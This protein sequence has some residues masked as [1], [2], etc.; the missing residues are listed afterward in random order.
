M[1]ITMILV[2]LLLLV[3]DPVV[4]IGDV[5]RFSSTPSVSNYVILDNPDFYG[6]EGSFSL[7]AWIRPR[8]NG[9]TQGVWFS[10]QVASSDDNEITLSATD[11]RNDLFKVSLASSAT[12]LELDVWSHSCH[13]WDLTSAT[14]R[15]YVNGV[16]VA[17]K[18]TASGRKLKAGGVLVLGQDQDSRGGGFDSSQAFSGDLY[19]IVVLDKKLSSEEVGKLYESGRCG[20]LDLNLNQNVVLEW[21]DFLNAKRNGDVLV[22]A[23]TCSQWE[24]VRGILEDLLEHLLKYHK[25]NE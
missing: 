8:N 18:A 4:S 11:S 5:M 23:G 7:C 1:K 20:E 3:L 13:T 19:N 6:M 12:I 17:N 25:F 16:E 15:A 2:T 14:R 24:L 10:Y 21:S 22:E 9:N